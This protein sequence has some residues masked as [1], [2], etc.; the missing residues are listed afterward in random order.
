MRDAASST[1]SAEARLRS[2]LARI[3]AFG[4]VGVAAEL[5]LLG[6]YESWRQWIPLAVLA[7]GLLST[8]GASWRGSAPALRLHRAAMGAFV[9]CG[10]LGLWFHYQGNVE[11]EV[12]MVPSIGGWELFAE[13][14]AGATPALAPGTMILLGLIGLAMTYRH[15]TLNRTGKRRTRRGE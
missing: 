12:E 10:L 2:A 1:T 9:A 14:M 15:P 5:A 13:A 8:A 6:H 11:F 3:L 7:I 4:I